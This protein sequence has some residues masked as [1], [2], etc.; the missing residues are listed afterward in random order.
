MSLSIYYLTSIMLFLDIGHISGTSYRSGTVPQVWH[1]PSPL[2]EPWL[3]KC[4]RNVRL[5]LGG[6]EVSQW[7]VVIIRIHGDNM[8]Q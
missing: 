1:A 7:I 5:R 4:S 2:A 6:N 3:Q 8:G